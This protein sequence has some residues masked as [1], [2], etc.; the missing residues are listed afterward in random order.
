MTGVL[1]RTGLYVA[2]LMTLA[3]AFALVMS[4]T[5]GTAEYV[6]SV[7]TLCLGLLLGSLSSVVIFLERKRQ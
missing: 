3:S 2:V 6:V 7:L 5:P 4:L 1:A